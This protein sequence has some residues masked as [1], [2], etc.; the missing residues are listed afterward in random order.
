MYFFL[1]SKMFSHNEDL[2]KNIFITTSV[3]EGKPTWDDLWLFFDEYCKK[4]AEFEL[5]S[6][7]ENIRIIHLKDEIQ[8][9]SITQ[10][11]YKLQT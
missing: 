7:P 5:R 6:K 4:V 11:N 9:I 10:E 2:P 3:I 8:N 1:Q